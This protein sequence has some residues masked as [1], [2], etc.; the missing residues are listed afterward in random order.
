MNFSLILSTTLK[1]TPFGYLCFKTY[2]KYPSTKS[3]SICNDYLLLYGKNL[4]PL[5]AIP[6]PKKAIGK[7]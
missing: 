1:N 5:I 7:G 4:N 3:L 2:G 6:F